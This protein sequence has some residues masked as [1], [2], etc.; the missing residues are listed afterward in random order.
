MALGPPLVVGTLPG[1]LLGLAAGSQSEAARC[2][3]CC[4]RSQVYRSLA[5]HTA[6]EADCSLDGR[7]SHRQILE[8]RKNHFDK[9]N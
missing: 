6:A 1:P 4:L 7:W 9:T 8:T 3:S 2:Q 5:H